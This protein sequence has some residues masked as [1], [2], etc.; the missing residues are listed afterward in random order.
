M[1]N[2][3]EDFEANDDVEEGLAQE[4]EQKSWENVIFRRY[5]CPCLVP[6]PPREFSGK[7]RSA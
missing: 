6:P 2:I 7:L 3:E 1:P 4:K 5:L